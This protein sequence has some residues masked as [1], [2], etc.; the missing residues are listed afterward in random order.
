MYIF[1][2][3]LFL[4]YGHNGW[5]GKQVCTILDDMKVNYVR[6]DCRA[7]NIDDLEKEILRYNPTHIM[8]LIGRTYGVYNN[9]LINNIDYLEQEGKLKENIRDN[10]YSPTVLAII[11]NK[12]KIHYTY[13]GTGCIYNYDDN[14]HPYEKEIN[15][16]TEDSPPNFFG[17]S[18]SVVKGYT[19][20][21]MKL[22]DNVLNVRIRMPISDDMSERNFINKITKYNKICSIY[23]SMTTL[24][25]LLP[26]MVD[27]SMNK[28][29][30]SINLINPGLISH[31]EILEMYKE[32]IDP[33]LS[34][35]N[36]T[37]DE[38]NQILKSKRCNCYMSSSKLLYYYPNV[39]DIKQSVRLCL[40]KMKLN[41]NNY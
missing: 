15:G 8:S 41:M 26:L 40:E 5:I 34:W 16:F 6:G 29:T 10:L 18:Y 13:L 31:N 4:I 17:S 14:E 1:N 24:P 32:I 9:I 20:K 11:S 35:E 7:E 33:N 12:H 39:M 19:D 2:K 3:M 37:L 25:E 21:I 23:N 28:I 30:G 36:F 38:Q 27:M 22:F